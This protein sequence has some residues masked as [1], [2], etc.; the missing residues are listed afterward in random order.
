MKVLI[1]GS[2]GQVGSYLVDA[3]RGSA[4][5]V[6]PTRAELDLQS[7]AS[8]R[9]AVRSVN[10]DWILHP[11][12][13]TAVD[14][15]ETER[16]LCFAINAAATRTFAEESLR[17]NAGLVTFSTDY[18][19]DGSADR[20]YREDDATAP[21]NVYGESKLL[22]EQS[23]QEVGGLYFNFRTSWVYSARG[24]NFVKTML[25]LASTRPELKVVADQ[26]GCPSSAREIAACVTALVSRP[27]DELGGKAGNYHLAGQGETTWFGFAQEV[28][29]Q[30]K[31]LKPEMPWV[32][33]E[34]VPS[35]AYVTPAR[36]PANSRLCCDLA[37]ERLALSM[38]EWTKSIAEVVQELLAQ[39]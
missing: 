17:I 28:I 39:Q 15:A 11:A 6:A 8:I 12:A 26:Q 10:P 9:E 36:R 13:Y 25:R 14:R 35:S 34:P 20:A 29:A 37:R 30:A 21:I 7:E 2:T 24:N 16:D 4:Q 38:P 22:A 32:E 27:K 1:T 3:M 23:L 19:F 33:P 18:V 31:K 5:V